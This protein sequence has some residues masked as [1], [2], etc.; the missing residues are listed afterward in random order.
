MSEL[1]DTFPHLEN[2]MIIIRKMVEA[3]VDA[4]AEITANDNVYR[5]QPLLL[6]K[7]SRGNLLAA[8]RNLGGRDFDKKK[9]IIAGIYP[10]NEPDRLVGL[11]EMY[12]YK[13]R[14]SQIT[15]GY[16]INESY[17]HKG[18]ATNA[19]KLMTAY[20]CSEMGIKTLKAFVMPA[21]VYSSRVLLRN[22]FTKEPDQVQG[23]DW[24]GQE[25]VDLDVYTFT[26]TA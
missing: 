7:K 9:R 5:Y 22:G 10:A 20:L 25:I 11:T 13:K 19:A 4:L 17:W 15:I 1:F 2:D 26:H 3:D 24:G 8:I 18:I 14:F 16:C 21:N 12:D 23:K 6:Y